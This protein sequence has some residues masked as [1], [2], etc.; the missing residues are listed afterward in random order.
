M[1]N[2]S[3]RFSGN[4]IEELSKNIPSSL[5]ALNELIKNAYDAFSPDVTIKISPSNNTITISDHGNGMAEDE[6][7]SLFHISKSSK[8]YGHEIEQNGVKRLTQGSKG[9]GFLSAFKFGDKVEW[10]TCKNGVRSTFSVCKSELISK[11]DVA[12]TKIPLTTDLHSENGTIITVFTSK[13]EIE[14]LLIDLDVEDGKSIEKLAATIID[15][16][17]NIK[18]EIENQKKITSTEK[19]K[20]FDKESEENQLFYVKY[21]PSKNEVDFYHKGEHIKSFPFTLGRTDYSISLELII[22]HFNRGKNSRSISPLNRRVHD[23][24]L[25]PLIYINRNLF[26][27][28]V[29]FD[30]ELLRK[31]SSGETL[32]QMIGRVNLT[33]KSKEIE[34]NS[35][36]TNFVENSLTKKLI[37]DLEDL[38]KLIQTKGA[39]LKKQLRKSKGVPTGK[40]IPSL[41]A[42][43]DEQKNRTA[44]IIIDKNRPLT[45][46]IPSDQIYLEEYLFQIKNSSGQIVEKNEVDILIDGHKSSNRVLLS[47]EE[48]CEKKISFKY[49][50][51]LTDLV[52]KEITLSFERQISPISGKTLDK[53]LFTIQSGSGYCVKI[54]IVSDIINAIDNAYSSKSREDYLPLIACSIRSIFEISSDKIIKARKQWFSKFDHS[55]LSITTKREVKDKLLLNVVNVILLLKKN[56]DLINEV[57]NV[58]GINFSTLA[59]LLD[60]ESFKSSVKTSHIGAHQSIRYLSKPKI[61]SCADTCGLFSVICDVLMNVNSANAAASSINKVDESD[62]DKYLSS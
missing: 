44:S 4:I 26:N 6:I 62:L 31:K 41:G 53:S 29:I 56:P 36:R 19:L 3:I 43:T 30:P 55:K 10:K 58:S 37:K 9:L 8:S 38:N 54:E 35:D 22:F 14:E 18:I 23:E 25:Y 48:P 32:P 45:F 16:S 47:I 13:S 52:S 33:S 5:F 20:K 39:E 17:F 59:N 15:D 7:N 57:A 49:I 46:Y 60:V 27:N 40:A 11:D 21:D 2:A 12:G 50:D 24:A 28:T 51:D 61:E 42:D 1:S 34:F